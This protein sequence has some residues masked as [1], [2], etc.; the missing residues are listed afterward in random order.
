M[1]GYD[2]GT[3]IRPGSSSRL[4]ITWSG[5]APRAST[6]ASTRLIQK[7]RKPKDFAPQASHPLLETKPIEQL[8]NLDSKGQVYP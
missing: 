1:P 3:R 6:G 7:V 4:R 8:P 5:A 2:T